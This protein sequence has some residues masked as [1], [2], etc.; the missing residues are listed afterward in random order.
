MTA[1]NIISVGV[2]CPELTPPKA[3]WQTDGRR[4]DLQFF[5]SELGHLLYCHLIISPPKLSKMTCSAGGKLDF[6]DV[7]LPSGDWSS[8]IIPFN[9]PLPIGE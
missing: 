1:I 5:P 7:H 9:F 6:P 8:H 3:S 4:G 2:N